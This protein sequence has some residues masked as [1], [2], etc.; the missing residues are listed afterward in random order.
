M[1]T[2]RSFKQEDY[3]M[4]KHWWELANQPPP[5]LSML[6]ESSTLILEI[7]NKPAFCLS[8]YLT[9][10]SEYAYLGNF[11]SDRSI[12]GPQRKEGSQILMNAILSFANALGYK[13][14]I[15]MT[16]EPKLQQRYKDMG[17]QPTISNLQAF[18]KRT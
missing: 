8:V 16:A 1:Y 11:I 12:Q 15:C 14:V 18:V 10:C 4:I 7:E 6:P 5:S 17:F 9:N 13:Q 3:P 2:I